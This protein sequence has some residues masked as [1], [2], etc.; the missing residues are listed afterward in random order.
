MQDRDMRDKRVLRTTVRRHSEDPGR[1]DRIAYFR[2]AGRHIIAVLDK[3]IRFGFFRSIR[4]EFRRISWIGS[5]AASDFSCRLNK[6]DDSSVARR[7]DHCLPS[8]LSWSI[9][10]ES[11]S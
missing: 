7:K 9:A 3:D 2:I 11:E 1:I 8:T 10:D 6:I 5:F 4:A